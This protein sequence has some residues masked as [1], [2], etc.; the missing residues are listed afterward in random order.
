MCDGFHCKTLHINGGGISQRIRL[1][2]ITEL[3][4]CNG[5]DRD[6]DKARSW[7]I[8]VKSAFL[9]DQEPDEEKCLVFG[10]LLIGPARTGTTN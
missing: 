4:V 3:K 2:A 5:K 10:D 9:H 6:E 8:K 7:I 1:S